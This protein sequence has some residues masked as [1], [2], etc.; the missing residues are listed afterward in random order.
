YGDA[1]ASYRKA[2]ALAPEQGAWTVRASQALDK[3]GRGK[4]GRDE[5]RAFVKAHPTTVDAE[6]WVAL[7][8]LEHDLGDVSRAEEAFRT[9]EKASEGKDAEAFFGLAVIAANKTDAKEVERT[10]RALFAI[11]PERRIEVERDP[12]FFRVRIDPKVKA[13]FTPALMAEAKAA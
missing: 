7:G 9:A 8:W 4:D 1:L 2:I 11:E 10:L 6:T 12:A 3:L 13:L 5:L